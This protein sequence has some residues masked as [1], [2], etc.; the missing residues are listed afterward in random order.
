ML[1]KKSFIAII[2]VGLALMASLAN[3]EILVYEPFV[4]VPDEA[5]AGADTESLNLGPWSDPVPRVASD[6]AQF[7]EFPAYTDADG[8]IL[9]SKGIGAV[10]RGDLFDESVALDA[11][12]T[13]ADGRSA[14][15]GMQAGLRDKGGSGFDRQHSRIRFHFDAS[16]L[17]VRWDTEGP[18]GARDN[19]LIQLVLQ[20]ATGG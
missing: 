8:V 20:G 16:D 17:E 18:G 6:N 10:L 11:P 5:F 15:I 2:S 13:F 1:R 12:A 14:W 19:Q 9:P 3:A 7:V 4:G